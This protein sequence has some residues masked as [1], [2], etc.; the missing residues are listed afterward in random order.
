MSSRGQADFPDFSVFGVIY[1]VYFSHEKKLENFIK[2]F[3][4]IFHYPKRV[5]KMKGLSHASGDPIPSKNS[6]TKSPISS[7]ENSK[8][9]SAS[10]TSKKIRSPKRS[11]STGRL[12]KLR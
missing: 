11:T 4:A 5:K 10:K 9:T 12:L 7:A 8:P 1:G 2:I 6:T 3:D